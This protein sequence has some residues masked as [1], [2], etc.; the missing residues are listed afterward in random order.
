[1][2]QDGSAD[3]VRLVVDLNVELAGVQACV[4]LLHA[5]DQ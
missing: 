1:M 5:G 4:C 2:E 3:F